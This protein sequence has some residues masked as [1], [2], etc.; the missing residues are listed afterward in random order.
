MNVSDEKMGNVPVEISHKVL[1]IVR[2]VL[3]EDI[4]MNSSVDNVASWDSMAYIAIVSYIED[5]FQIKID[6]SNIDNFISVR[7]IVLE[8]ENGRK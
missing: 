7:N 4:D 1:Q 2:E 5:E 6:E 3:N 8:I